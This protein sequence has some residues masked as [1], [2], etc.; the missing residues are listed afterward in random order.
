VGSA[1]QR[2]KGKKEARLWFPGPAHAAREER[3]GS[4]QLG[5]L[6]RKETGRSDGFPGHQQ[7][8]SSSPFLFF[9]LHLFSKAILKMDF[10]FKSNKT[11]TTPQN[12]SNA[13]A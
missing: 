9:F 8:V 3:K 13:T 12:K 7:Q 5:P 10:K 11:K 4:A 2:S 1:R 6:A